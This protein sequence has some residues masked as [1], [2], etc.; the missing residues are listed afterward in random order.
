VL[1]FDP[2][3]YRL[4]EQLGASFEDTKARLIGEPAI[5]EQL[6]GALRTSR[7]DLNSLRTSISNNGFLRHE[8]LIV[9]PYDG[10]RFLVLEGNRRLAAVRSLLR[11]PDDR[12]LSRRV[13]ASLVTLPCFVLEGTP[14]KHDDEALARYRREASVYVGLRHLMGP[15]EWQPTGRYAFLAHL[16]LDDHWSIA[17]VESRFGRTRHRILNDIRGHILY[18]QFLE[19]L[20]ECGAETNPVTYNAFAEIGKAPDVYQWLGWDADSRSYHRQERVTHLFKHL[21]D[22]LN[23]EELGNES[24]A[25]EDARQHVIAEKLIRSLRDM[26]KLQDPEVNARLNQGDFAEAEGLFQVRK[27]GPLLK[28]LRE[29]YALLRNVN[30][31]ELSEEV[32]SV[33]ET[34]SHGCWERSSSSPRSCVTLPARARRNLRRPL[35]RRVSPENLKERARRKAHD[36]V[37]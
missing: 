21:F 18:R 17:E 37:R 25:E 30:F 2:G 36:E 16:V 22:E 3:N 24:D 8:R 10:G 20:D 7:F 19:F 1:L 33:M 15:K 34:K 14:V 29:V 27:Q 26:L 31:F 28:R 9:V 6:Y 35:L 32:K 12:A 13:R 11:S 5:Q 23:D 4:F